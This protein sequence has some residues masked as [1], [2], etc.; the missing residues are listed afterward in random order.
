M[1][2]EA[3]SFNCPNCGTPLMA[4]GMKQVKCMYCGST[5]IVPEELRDQSPAQD[6]VDPADLELLQSLDPYPSGLNLQQRQQWLVQNGVETTTKVKFVDDKGITKN[7]NPLV[8]LELDVRP[9]GT[10]P[11]FAAVSINVPR[12]SVP[13]AGDKVQIKYNPAD[14]YDVAV[15]IDGQFHQD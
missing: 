11:Y 9:K 7:G 4:N 3:K 5:V 15:K 8:T 12:T 2:S 1:T 14:C 10:K 6:Q 13:R